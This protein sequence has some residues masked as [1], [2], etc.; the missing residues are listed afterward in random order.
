MSDTRRPE[1]DEI[2]L[3]TFLKPVATGLKNLFAASGSYIKLLYKNIIFLAVV[4]ILFTI[5]G[6]SV[7]FV[8]P[9]LYKTDAVFSSHEIP[10][11][12]CVIMLNNLQQISGAKS[13]KAILVEKLGINAEQ[14][15][16]VSSFEAKLMKDSF[17]INDLDTVRN[18]FTVTLK[19]SNPNFISDIQNG[20]VRYLEQN[21][22][23]KIRKDSKRKMLMGLKQNLE[24]KIKSLDSLSYIVNSSIT[25][26]SQGQ[27]II[28]GEPVDPVSVYQAGVNYYRELL[29]IE[30]ALALPE[31]IEVIQ[32]F[33]ASVKPNHPKMNLIMMYFAAA[34]L[35]LSMIIIP[36]RNKN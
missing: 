33:V 20:L 5:A 12:L 9:K 19:S 7:R 26:R 18:F 23:A 28:L 6:F 27:G 8:I 31:N 21:E 15:N 11:K 29:D 22:F 17:F 30:R 14:A 13:N 24:T 34:G 4:T 25:P 36:I 35:L 1:A 32:P 16:S 2:D 10:H 3:F